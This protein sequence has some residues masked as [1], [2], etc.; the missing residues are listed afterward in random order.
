M[1]FA[2]TKA[3]VS[4]FSDNK[5]P[6]RISLSEIPKSL[7][8]HSLRTSSG[9]YVSQQL[10]RNFYRLNSKNENVP[11]L[12]ESCKKMKSKWICTVHK[13][14]K[15]SDGTSITATDFVESYKRILSKPAPRSDLLL[16]MR[17]SKSDIKNIGLKVL[18]DKKFEIEWEKDQLGD[19]FILMSPLFVPL[20]NGEFKKNV[21]SGPFQIDQISTFK[22][23]MSR[24]PHYFRQQTDS[25]KIHWLLM[26]E[27]LTAQ[28]FEKKELDFL[29][30]VPTALIGQMRSRPEFFDSPVLR[31]DALFFGPSLKDDFKFREAVTRGLDYSQMQI[32]FNSKTRPGCAGVP[33]DFYEGPEI[34]YETQKI[35]TFADAPKNLSYLY[36]SLGGEDHRRLAEWLQ[37]QFQNLFQTKLQVRGFENKIFLD[38]I[39]SAPPALFR[40]GLSPEN[41]TCYGI[42]E[43]FQ[44]G[45][46][47]NLSQIQS[48][49]FDQIL[50]KLKV[51]KNPKKLCREAL[52][53][54]L[55]QKLMIPT[56]RIYFSYM[57]QINFE[58]LELNLLNHMDLSKLKS[59]SK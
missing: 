45:H 32:L 14:A 17:N 46:P 41:P 35:G 55:D 1:A 52:V 42:L 15:W 16:N 24:N 13:N 6:F 57:M 30:R 40:R 51:A 27:S 25:L 11:E 59:V 54:L 50:A 28:A 36:S 48:P 39:K 43:S 23:E 10:F 22:I 37:N 2:E 58:G 19:E 12:G 34:C 49:E 4:Q 31:M 53:Y 21:F 38:K 20:P 8:P 29:R 33:L 56:G 44:S 3:P 18:S 26:D 7:D 9:Q 5:K 47:D